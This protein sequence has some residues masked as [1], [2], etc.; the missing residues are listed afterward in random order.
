MSF[1]AYTETIVDDLTRQVVYPDGHMIGL[2]HWFPFMTRRLAR[3]AS[4][5]VPMPQCQFASTSVPVR[6]RNLLASFWLLLLL[7]MAL[8]TAPVATEAATV[9][10][11]PKVVFTKGDGAN[12]KQAAN[13]DRITSNVWLTRGASQ[14][15]YNVANEASF[16]HSVS[17]V[18]TEWASGTTSNYKSL[19]YT[20]WETWA[21]SMGGPPATTG[22]NAVLHLKTD[23]IYLDIKFLSWSARPANGGGFSYERSTGGS[24]APS[25]Y[26]FSINAVGSGNIISN[27]VGIDC[28]GTCSA[29]FNSGS[30]VTLTATAAS[31]FTFTGW[32]G[33]CTGTG[34]CTVSMSA[35]KNATAT[36]AAPP[37]ATVTFIPGWNL[38]GNSVE[39]SI[40][41]TSMFG[42]VAKVTSVWKWIPSGA[43]WAFYS[44]AQTDGGAA[45]A[46]SKGYDTLTTINAGEGFWVN[47]ATSFSVSLPSGTAVNS[48]TFKPAVTNPSTP[49]G[50]HAL[51]SGWSLIATGDGPTPAQF[52][53]AIATSLATTPAPGNVYTNLT[54]LWVW[55]ATIQAWYFWAPALANSGGLTSFIS[56][57]NYLDSAT[58]PATPTGT[59]SPTTG[60]WVNIP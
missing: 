18:D 39:A 7:S 22:V 58:M 24:S 6:Q 9:W 57:R 42:D 1:H 34:V 56:N 30:S 43:K 38:V 5:T 26:L 47:A 17:P 13:Q 37:G 49:G 36:F 55:D 4:L 29:S 31:G 53:A 44:P 23:D 15:L 45:F 46:A 10:S 48:S 40:T 16:A 21:K 33:D 8:L 12:P 54:T 14:G 3:E 27:P 35:A 60:F 2:E 41:V 25:S 28:S 11:G 50:T 19:T 52:D 59:L 51:P 20:D 32:S